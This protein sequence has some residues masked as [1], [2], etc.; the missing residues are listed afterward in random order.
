MGQV[1]PMVLG[2]VWLR[3]A[4]LEKH[5]LDVF[6]HS[7]E[8]LQQGLVLGRIVLP[9]M[10]RPAL[11]RKD[12]ANKHHLDHVDEL[13][14]LV[15]HVLD[16]L[17]ESVQLHRCTPVQTLLWPGG[18]SHRGSGPEFESRG[19]GGVAQLSDIEP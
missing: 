5:L 1:M 14:I 19:L 8:E 6:V 17:L 16:T 7:A 15:Y 18:E 4:G 11:A 10:A 12:P 3:L 13:D 2:R 9:Q